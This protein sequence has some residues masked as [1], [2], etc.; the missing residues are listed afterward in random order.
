MYLFYLVFGFIFISIISLITNN[1]YYFYSINDFTRF[2]KPTEKTLYNDIGINI[3]PILLWNLFAVPLL[4]EYIYFGLGTILNIFVSCLVMYIFINISD[5]FDKEKY[6]IFE[7]IFIL[8][9][10]MLGQL[11]NVLVIKISNGYTI[12]PFVSFA[13]LVILIVLFFIFRVAPPKISFFR[14][15]NE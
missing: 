12:S 13:I 8:I 6:N 10:V 11:I 4:G 15:K 5:L 9:A 14:Q 7:S 2:L 1:I 3:M